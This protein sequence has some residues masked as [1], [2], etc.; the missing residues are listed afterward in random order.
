LMGIAGCATMDI[1]AILKKK[2]VN[3]KK[4]DLRVE[5]E[6]AEEHPQ[7]FTQIDFHYT[8]Y[9]TGIQS[10]D[11][12]RAIDLTDSKYCGAT[13]MIKSTVTVNY[14]YEIVAAE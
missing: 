12:D 7:V 6:R 11:I 3:L 14:H 10:K 13:A 1:I 2:R 5:A 9:G 4:F 8:F